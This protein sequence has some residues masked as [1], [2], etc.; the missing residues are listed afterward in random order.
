MAV[1]VKVNSDL[2]IGCGLCIASYPESFEFDGEGKS[3]ATNEMDDQAAEEAVTSCP[4]G[5]IV[6]E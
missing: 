5:A 1:K 4:A 6:K 2:C 3:V